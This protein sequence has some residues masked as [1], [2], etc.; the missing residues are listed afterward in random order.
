MKVIHKSGKRK[1][2]IARATMKAGKGNVKINYQT[3][4]VYGSEMARMK[5]ME[6]LLLAEDVSK[7]FDINVNVQGGGWQSQAEAV[8][9]AIARC[10][11]EA[12]KPLK[13]KFLEY[14]RNLVVADTRRKE[15]C[16]P[17]DSKARAKRQKS[18]R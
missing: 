4:G 6:P 16:K 11:V 12:S 8:R 1:T 18:Y 14:D 17:N 2:A 10:L 7:K 15:V 13:I 9:L 3:L 5:I